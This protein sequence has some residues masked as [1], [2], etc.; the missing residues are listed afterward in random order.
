MKFPGLN[1]N[2]YLVIKVELA[3]GVVLN[4]NGTRY[5]NTENANEAYDIFNDYNIAKEFAI[6]KVL[7]NSNIQCCIYD[8][9]NKAIFC[10]DKNGEQKINNQI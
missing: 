8:S 1:K 7:N 5:K 10:Y 2:Q 3:T 4:N 6:L 9:N